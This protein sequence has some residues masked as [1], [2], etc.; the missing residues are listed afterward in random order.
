MLEIMS[1]HYGALIDDLDGDWH[2]NF[3]DLNDLTYDLDIDSNVVILH[4][5][6]LRP[7]QALSSPYFR[8]QIILALA[9]A[10]RMTRHVEWLDGMLGRYHPQTII[11]IGRVCVADTSV[12]KIKFAWEAKIDED[13][14]LWK[15]ILCGDET[16]M[17]VAFESSLE[18]YLSSGMDDEGAMRKAMAVA[19]NQWFS[20]PDR[21]RECDH[22]TMNLID[23]MIAD[24]VHFDG[25]RLEKNAI[26]C[27]TLV[28]G[29]D[30]SYLD[31]FLQDDVL[32]NPYYAAI[33]DP[34]NQ[35]HFM[36]IITDMNTIRV[37]GL[38]FSDPVLAARFALAEDTEIQ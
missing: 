16:D 31:R 29:E 25:K 14:T 8:P 3:D 37:G 5:H 30:D 6:G 23:G 26:T 20:N 36:Q 28:P 27:L 21:V 19:F 33:T 24:R 10:L 38:V 11:L 35:S 15:H 9:E 1:G 18:K 4:N 13:P 34:I 7:D 17:A 32:K 12:Q 2:V 22:D